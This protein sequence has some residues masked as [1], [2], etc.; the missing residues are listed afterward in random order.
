MNY[1][2]TLLKPYWLYIILI[3]AV[4]VLTAKI[5]L[6]SSD[7]QGCKARSAII[8][9]QLEQQNLAILK[10]SEEEKRI[11]LKHEKALMAVKKEKAK[12]QKE[13]ISL[14]QEK[15]P[16]KCEEAIAWAVDA[17]KNF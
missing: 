4:V 17:S 10:L 11:K 1:I 2:L 9:A 7:L 13:L 14:S 3:T 12:H 6:I 16:E 8:A 15:V 5:K